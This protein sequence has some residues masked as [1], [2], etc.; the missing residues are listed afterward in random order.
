VDERVLNAL[1]ARQREEFMTA[2]LTIVETLERV[3]P[4]GEG[5]T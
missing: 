4:Q 5:Q 3:A 1:P 2:L